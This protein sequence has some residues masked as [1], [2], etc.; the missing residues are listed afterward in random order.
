MKW[1]VLYD[2]MIQK[3]FNSCG[4]NQYPK[5][6]DTKHNLLCGEVKHLYVAITRSKQR[7]WIYEEKPQYAKPMLDYWKQKGII[8]FRS[9]DRSM[10]ESMHNVSSSED[11]RQRGIQV[12]RP[13]KRT[14]FCIID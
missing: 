5:F 12:C 7:L 14:I 9:F 3:G 10:L 8:Q 2:F 4:Q 6:D 13:S 11:W 1:R